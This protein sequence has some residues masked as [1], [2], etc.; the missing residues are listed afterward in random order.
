[1]NHPRLIIAAL[2]GLLSLGAVAPAW[3]DDGR[4]RARD[5]W[6]QRHTVADRDWQNRGGQQNRDWR[7]DRWQAANNRP[8]VDRRNR[9]WRGDRWQTAQNGPDRDRGHRWHDRR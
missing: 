8:D 5:R 6:Q 1:M 4:D 9:D 7:R 3:A 2:T